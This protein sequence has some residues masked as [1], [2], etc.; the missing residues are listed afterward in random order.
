MQKDM[1]AVRVAGNQRAA[2]IGSPAEFKSNPRPSTPR[3]LRSTEALITAAEP[4][5]N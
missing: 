1:I 4:A 2:I 3:D 5:A